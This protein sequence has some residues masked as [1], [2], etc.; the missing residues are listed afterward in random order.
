MGA[1]IK[2]PTQ[3][4]N[5]IDEIIKEMSKNYVQNQILDN[6]DDYPVKAIS[7]YKNNYVNEKVDYALLPLWLLNVEYNNQKYCFYINGNNGKLK[8]VFPFSLSKTFGLFCSIFLITQ[9]IFMLIRF[10]AFVL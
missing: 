1:Y 10:V 4:K 6:S 5:D 7:E 3:N 8:G 9:L 2:F